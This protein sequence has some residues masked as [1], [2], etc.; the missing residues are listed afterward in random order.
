MLCNLQKVPLRNITTGEL[1][2]R[3]LHLL[4]IIPYLEHSQHKPS[5][6]EGA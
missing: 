6:A 3:V 2:N 1:E 4:Y 5:Q